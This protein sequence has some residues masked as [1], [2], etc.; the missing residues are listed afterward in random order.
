MAVPTTNPWN[1]ANFDELHISSLLGLGP[2]DFSIVPSGAPYWTY[3]AAGNYVALTSADGVALT[4]DLNI[5]LS[6]RYTLEVQARFPKLPNDHNIVAGNRVGITVADDSSRGFSLYFAKTGLAIGRVDDF[7]SVATLPDTADLVREVENRFTRLRIAVDGSGGLAYVFIAPVTEA[8]PPIEAII[9]IEDTPLGIPD[10]FRLFALGTPTQPVRVEYRLIQVGTDLIIPNFPPTAN[11]GPDRVLPAGQVARLDG[12]ASFDVEGAQLTYQWRLVD[13]PFGSIYAHDN[14]S[15]TTVDDGDADGFT[16]TLAFTASTLADWVAPGD[17]LQIQGT[18]HVIAT[19]DNGSGTLTV[20][21]D[22][23]PDSFTSVPFR[24]L[25]QSILV[26]P[27]TEQPSATP[28]IQGTYRFSLVVNDGESDSAEAEVLVN[29]V[30]AR[31]PFGIEPDTKFIWNALGDDWRF[32]ENR[33]VFTEAWTG[34][35]QVLAGKLL[36]VWQHHYNFNL[37]DA[38]PYFQR[39]WLPYRTLVEETSPLTVSVSPRWGFLKAGYDWALGDPAITGLALEIT[40]V[41][42][43]TTTVTF[44]ANDLATAVADINS[45]S[46]GVVATAVGTRLV[47]SS[48]SSYFQVEPGSTA[49]GLLGFAVGINS[50][51]SGTGGSR[52]TERTY[53][54]EEGINLRSYGV[55]NGDLLLLNNGQAFLIERVI[56]DASDPTE[57]QRIITYDSLPA[58]A[59]ET[60]EIP[61]TVTSD[62]DYGIEGVYPGDVVKAEVFDSTTGNVSDASGRVRGYRGKTLGVDLG[63]L[64]L[65]YSDLNRYEVTVLGV[66]R[67]KAIRIDEEVVS[68][69]QLQDKIPQSASPQL[70]KENLDYYLAPFFRDIG[71][72]PIPML[73]FADATFIDP[74]IEPPDVFWAEITLFSN[75]ENIEGTFGQLAEFSRDQAEAYG[76]DFS[77]KAGV[78]GL[79]YAKL[80]GPEVRAIKIGAQIL[81]GEP[82]AEEKGIIIEIQNAF[83]PTQGRII[84]QDDDGFDPPRTD[85]VRSYVYKRDPLDATPTSGIEENPATGAPYAVGDTVEQFAG[86]GSGVDV[87]DYINDP[88]WFVPFVRAGL[89]GELEK[90]HKFVVQYNLDLVT[91]ANVSLL[92]QFVLGS[93]PHYTFPLLLGLKSLEED[94][95]VTDV[96]D[97]TLALNEIDS[98]CTNGPAYV[99]DDWRSDG[100]LWAQYDGGL[101]YDM[102]TDCVSDTVELV[103]TVDWAGGAVSY[104]MGFFYSTPVIDVDGNVGAP[105]STFTPTY[106]QVLPAG[107]YVVNVTIDNGND[108]SI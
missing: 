26:G 59:T 91:L 105:G 81:L 48:T 90:F 80:R 28:D 30:A 51:L 35:A 41:G 32:V 76:D 63:D 53:R 92:Y 29:V 54:V 83:S 73:Q 74:D 100:T 77:Y 66:K 68:V 102:G 42:G 1:L 22:T 72:A 12:R 25:R 60:W 104:G 52:V 47:L 61:A 82:F 13:A 96:L 23:I 37:R 31:A 4:G 8:F 56:S 18:R 94:I 99:Y 34:T 55:S 71:D 38:Q 11:A 20:A 33:H 49:N 14:S 36:E 84:I 89:F 15:G 98:M 21:E 17:V 88:D 40:P 45:A 101:F 79:L 78:A 43:E 58:D 39:K 2:G 85:V 69:P 50:S 70:W 108:F 57:Y 44:T 65:G 24:V 5:P 19:V 103:I 10:T 62:V 6:T 95:D 67:R 3:D 106:G 87:I 7:G 97:Q 93:R 75:D 86:L 9:P 107:Q 64:A 46:P 16:S 27:T